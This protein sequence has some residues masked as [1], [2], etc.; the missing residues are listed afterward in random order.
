MTWWLHWSRWVRDWRHAG[1]DTT[2]LFSS[3][4]E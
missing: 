3:P 4:D 1:I 2:E